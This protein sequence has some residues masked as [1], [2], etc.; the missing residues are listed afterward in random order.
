MISDP[1]P[2]V[3]F[4]HQGRLLEA[5]AIEGGR[6]ANEFS[7]SPLVDLEFF[8]EA[9]VGN[10]PVDDIQETEERVQCVEHYVPFAKRAFEERGLVYPFC[11]QSSRASLQPLP[12][13]EV[14]ARRCAEFAGDVG[15]GNPTAKKFESRAFR[16]L[17]RLIGGWAVSVGTPRTGKTGPAKAVTAFRSLLRST[18]IGA[19]KNPDPSHSGDYGVDAVYVLGREW[20]GPVVFLQAKN[21]SFDRA[22][23]AEHLTRAS[24]AL[25]EWFGHR[26]DTVRNVIT[27]F[28]VNTVLTTDLKHSA[29]ADCG[30][31]SGYH[32]LDSVDILFAETES[33]DARSRRDELIEF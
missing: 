32:V 20:G 27:V 2:D 15:I 9:P 5:E 18:E 23:F 21:S 25:Q 3:S 28:A 22:K 14:L 10:V 24:F 13:H 4:I 7:M 17:H 31:G 1:F 11:A 29:F 12:G 30:L 26:I 8:D 6:R 33:V 19:Y 16:A